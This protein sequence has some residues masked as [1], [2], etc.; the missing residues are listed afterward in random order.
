MRLIQQAA[1]RVWGFNAISGYSRNN[2]AIRNFLPE[3]RLLHL[4]GII[5]LDRPVVREEYSFGIRRY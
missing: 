3:I 4:N 2:L 1:S 5:I